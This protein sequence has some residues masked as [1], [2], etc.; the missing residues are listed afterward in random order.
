MFDEATKTHLHSG[1]ALLV[2]SVSVDG[3]PHA[4]RGFGLTVLGENPARVRLLIDADDVRTQQN[5]RATGAIAIT[6][7]DVALLYSLQL[8]GSV[9]LLE[10][11]TAADYAKARQYNDDF[12]GDIEATDGYAREDIQPWIATRFMACVV[13]V[14]EIFDQTPGPSAGGSMRSEP[15]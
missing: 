2:G 6:T 3:R 11:A 14:R 15:A 10:E 8:K 1:C 9:E 13:T 12:L 7:A 4:G 5:L